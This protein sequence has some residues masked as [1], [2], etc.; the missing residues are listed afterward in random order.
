M[1]WGFGETSKLFSILRPPLACS[2]FINPDNRNRTLQV[3]KLFPLGLREHVCP[4][5]TGFSSV[6][7]AE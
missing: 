6:P 4:G 2:H 1:V 5:V 3:S 7:D